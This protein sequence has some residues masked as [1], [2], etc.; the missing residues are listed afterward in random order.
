MKKLFALLLALCLLVP[1]FAF[2]EAAESEAEA[3]LTLHDVRYYFE[4][5]LNREYFF[6]Y[7]EGW[8]DTFREKG[9][10]DFWKW[11]TDQIPFDA[12]YTESDFGVRET[13]RDGIHMMLLEM[14]KPEQTPDC[15]RIWMCF[16]KETGK[17]WYYTVEYDNFMG[18]AWFLCEWVKTGEGDDSWTHMDYGAVDAVT[19]SAE[20]YEARLEEEADMI[21]GMIRGNAQ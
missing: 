15:S 4:H 1:C 14:P 13:D 6:T 21:A 9:P 8:F 11:F 3:Q 18:E 20:D 10:Y 2:G 7:T 12:P 17:A 16:E 5:R 19:A